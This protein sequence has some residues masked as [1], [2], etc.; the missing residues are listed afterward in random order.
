MPCV[1][2]LH[3]NT[4]D[5]NG[6]AGRACARLNKALLKIGVDSKIKV[7][8]SFKQNVQVNTFAASLLK[9]GLAAFGILLERYLSSK[10]VKPLK[11]PFSYPA[12]GIDISNDEAVLDADIIHLHWINHAFLRPKDLEK[13]VAINKP[14]VW[15]FHDSNAFT[16]GCHVRY[17]CT[18]FEQQCGNCPVLKNA[19]PTDASNKIW[20]W[21]YQAYQKL[22]F[23]IIAP[24]NWMMESVKRS[25][26]LSSRQVNVIPNT[27]DVS[28]F[29]SY[30]KIEARI[31]LVLPLDKFIIMS[32]FMPSRNDLH[33]GTPYLVEALNI[34]MPKTSAEA[35]E[36]VVFGN[37]DNKNT[38]EFAMPARF[39]G[40]IHD[41]EKLAL[42]YSAAD[43]FVTASLDDNL[44]N[45][46]MESLACGTPVV[47]FTTGGIPDMVIHLHNGYLAQYRSADDLANGINWVQNHQDK[48]KLKIQARES[49]E[50]RFSENLV[51]Q[52]HVE[53]YNNVLAYH[54]NNHV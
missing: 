34:L 51:A 43:V 47:A 14:I 40:T 10:L 13:L 27:L 48:L 53:L 22:K 46:V 20:H 6:G 8:Y 1:K 35:M 29:K 30:D 17:S 24:S 5:G 44:P 42:C 18:H 15:T 52:Q 2:I 36:L 31:K 4:Y 21:K 25:S 49:I 12:W 39:L 9:K 23:D 50:K 16:G 54:D 37:R 26:L 7:S 45:T 38:P 33:K 32:G 11:I 41:D 19:N 3:L 28:V